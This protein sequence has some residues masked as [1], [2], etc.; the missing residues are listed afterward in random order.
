MLVIHWSAVKNTK[1]ILKNG[2]TK[3]KNGLYCFPLTGNKK[4]DH[5][6]VTAFN[7][8]GYRK[9]RAQYNG[10]IFK[11]EKEDMPACFG[12]AYGHTTRDTFKM[13]ITD[14]KELELH[15]QKRVFHKIGERLVKRNYSESEEFKKIINIIDKMNEEKVI[16]HSDLIK[17]PFLMY[18][19]AIESPYRKTYSLRY[20][21]GHSVHELHSSGCSFLGKDGRINTDPQLLLDDSFSNW[22][23]S[24]SIYEFDDLIDLFIETAKL[25]VNE[26]TKTN[27]I[28][29]NNDEL[30]NNA[31]CDWQIILSR[32]VSPDRIKK[33]VSSGD[34]FGKIIHSKKKYTENKDDNRDIEI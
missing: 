20:T 33:I 12:H 13:E 24:K 4:L 1:K 32:S 6:W 16:P 23:E 26:N 22:L 9:H 30:L 11:I 3:S 7:Q 31:F 18:L 14:L 10:F 17:Y 2:I 19:L 5:W 34:E 21:I 27:I 29:E 15:Y 25:E 8:Y 28:S